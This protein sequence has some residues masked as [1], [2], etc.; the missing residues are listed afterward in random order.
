[1]DL[2]WLLDVRGDFPRQACRMFALVEA[3]ERREDVAAR[4]Y[5]MM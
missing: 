5:D 2:W 3:K 4:R 1:M